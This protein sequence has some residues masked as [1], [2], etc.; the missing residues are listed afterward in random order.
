MPTDSNEIVRILHVGK[1]LATEFV[2]AGRDRNM[3]RLQWISYRQTLQKLTNADVRDPSVEDVRRVMQTTTPFSFVFLDDFLHLTDAV[4]SVRPAQYIV[5]FP[6]SDE[7]VCGVWGVDFGISN[8]NISTSTLLHALDD[9]GNNRYSA[10]FTINGDRY[11]RTPDK[12][13]K[14]T[15]IFGPKPAL[16]A[17]GISG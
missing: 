5:G 13:V 14:G 2:H 1:D 9:I 7:R 17:T 4:R 16:V 3:G 11:A 8:P 10:E 12:Y 15:G 6:I